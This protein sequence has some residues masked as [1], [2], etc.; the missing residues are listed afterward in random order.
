MSSLNADYKQVYV[1]I[2]EYIKYT[3]QTANSSNSVSPTLRTNS[4]ESRN[5]KLASYL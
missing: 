5:G 4:L 3:S 1:N 2:T